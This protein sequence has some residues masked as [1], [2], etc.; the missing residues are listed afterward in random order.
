MKEIP[1][2]QG[3]VALVDDEDY[4]FLSR[5]KWCAMRQG[6]DRFRAYRGTE[7][8]GRFKGVLMH[9]VITGAL[10]GQTVDHINRDPLDNRKENLRLCCQAKQSLNRTANRT[11]R[12]TS[13]YKGVYW[14]KDIR[15]WRARFRLEYLGTFMSQITAA[16]AYDR[17]AK[18]F[19]PDFALL[20]F[21]VRGDLRAA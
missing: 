8:K 11:G 12:K 18:A 17:A 13:L 15:R 21:P 4:E 9:R 16:E 10:P 14:Q 7:S 5:W 20:N 19:D 6:Y 3:K 2:T 1:L